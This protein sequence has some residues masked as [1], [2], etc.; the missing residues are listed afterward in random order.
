MSTDNAKRKESFE[1]EYLSDNGTPRPFLKWAGGKR[2]LL[3]ELQSRVPESYSTYYEPFVGGGALF[4]K[5]RPK[6]AY[7]SDLNPEL[8]NAYEVIKASV[9]RLIRDLKKHV[10]EE[11]YFYT[12]RNVDRTG[13]FQKWSDVRRASRLIYLNKTCFNGLYRVNSKG[14]FNAPFGRYTDPAIFDP[15]NLH[16]C[17]HVLSRARVVIASYLEIEKSITKE[18][19]AYF[20]PPYAP[21]NGTSYFTDYSKEG[22]DNGMQKE[23]RDLCR[24]L[25]RRGIKFMVSN[26]DVELINDLYK[27]FNIEQVFASRAINSNSAK[28]GKITEL[29]IRNYD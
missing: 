22:F 10:Y 25:D 8:I 13:A 20:D 3:A 23:L 7:L 11:E 15:E 27:G 5:L 6:R 9:D 18:D 14:H 4:F 28:R 26:S 12:I 19:F 17:S 16:A 24:R 21:I 1:I 29:I 2:Q